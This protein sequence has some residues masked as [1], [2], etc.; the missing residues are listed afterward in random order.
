MIYLQVKKNYHNCDGLPS[1]FDAKKAIITFGSAI[2]L[3]T[4]VS[5]RNQALSISSRFMKT[6]AKISYRS[7]FIPV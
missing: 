5:S 7:K 3:V 4:L 2:A 1:C 6:A